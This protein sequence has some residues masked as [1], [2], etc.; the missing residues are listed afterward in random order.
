[1]CGKKA[2][3]VTHSNQDIKIIAPACP[4]EG[5]AQV[6][7][8]F[9]DFNMQLSFTYEAPQPT[10]ET[11]VISQIVPE[12]SSPVK[13]S[14]IEITGGGFGTDASAVEVWLISQEK[15]GNDY[16]MKIL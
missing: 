15:G 8:L 2:R 1:M 5:V 14:H 3:V 9:K 6:V 11:I 10:E 12:S 4:N 16:P 7:L 13:K